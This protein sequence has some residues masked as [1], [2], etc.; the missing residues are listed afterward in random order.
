MV[1]DV[2]QAMN[3]IYGNIS[4]Y[5]GDYN[6]IYVVGQSA[7]AHLFAN[8]LLNQSEREADYLRRSID[9]DELSDELDE[10]YGSYGSA[11]E[12]PSDWRRASTNSLLRQSS[13][14]PLECESYPSLTPFRDASGRSTA[15]LRARLPWRSSKLRAFIG[16]SGP[17]DLIMFR[18]YFHSQGLHRS[19]QD[20]IFGVSVAER[21]RLSPTLRVAS[22]EF[23]DSHAAECL[24]PIYLLH[25]DADVTCPSQSSNDFAAALRKLESGPKVLLRIYGGKSHTDPIIEDLLHTEFDDSCDVLA[26]ILR[27]VLGSVYPDS[28]DSTPAPLSPSPSRTGIGQRKP[29]SRRKS[30]L[31]PLDTL[32]FYDDPLNPPSLIAAQTMLPHFVIAWAR[33]INPF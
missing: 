30:R 16:L 25:G 7:G 17:Y 3:W 14:S 2:N 26:D 24:P 1:Q 12:T 31:R 11:E 9:P 5:G 33:W 23:H 20:A 15:R 32:G 8:A 22:Q 28:P 4:K 6:H 18:D 19:V 27:I 21:E 29:V 13:E 10:G